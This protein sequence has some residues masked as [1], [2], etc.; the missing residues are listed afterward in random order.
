M[1]RSAPFLILVLTGACS[2]PG[3]RRPEAVVGSVGSSP[4]GR[5][6]ARS[7]VTTTTIARGPHSG[8]VDPMRL[9]VRDS[10]SWERV[11]AQANAHLVELPQGPS[12]DFAQRI[13]VVAALGRRLST[14][15]DNAIDSVVRD[16]RFVRIYVRSVDPGP[17]C[18][19]GMAELRPFH[20]VS[21][22]LPSRSVVFEELV[23]NRA[24]CVP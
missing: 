4:F 15:Y 1:I 3:A 5:D 20:A 12:V 17:G 2:W 16:R 19:A 7:R 13:V 9:V 11:W 8:F 21:M 10:A 24:P 22:P 6:T 23:V 18:M 14:S